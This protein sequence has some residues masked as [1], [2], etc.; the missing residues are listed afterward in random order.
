VSTRRGLLPTG[1]HGLSTTGWSHPGWTGLLDPEEEVEVTFAK[2]VV[3]TDKDQ[4]KNGGWASKG[5]N[6]N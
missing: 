1:D 5:K 4:C 2:D 6:K 3:L